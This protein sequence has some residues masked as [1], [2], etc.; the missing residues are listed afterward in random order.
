MKKYSLWVKSLCFIL[1]VVLFL[2]M[3]V[4][5]LGF[6]AAESVNMYG[7]EDYKEWR[8][9]RHQNMA[10]TLAAQVMTEYAAQQS[11]SPQWLLEQTG[12]V[13]AINNG[14]NWYELAEEDW[15]YT[16]LDPNGKIVA[17]TKKEL[18]D[19]MTFYFEN[20]ASNY[21]VIV[22]P[23]EPPIPETTV[24]DATEVPAYP[25]PIQPEE[26]VDTTPTQPVTAPTEASE[27]IYNADEYYDIYYDHTSDQE[28]WVQYDL[29]QGYQV[30][31]AVRADHSCYYASNG[32]PME[33][34]EWLFSVRYLLIAVAAGSLLLFAAVLVFLMII[35]GRSPKT[36]E[37]IPKALNCLP[38]DLY[39]A[40]A[41][42]GT[43]LG[44][45]FIYE[46]MDIVFSFDVYH[47]IALVLACSCSVVIAT[48][49]IGFF[50]ALAAQCKLPGGF[51]W[52]HT[53]CG[54]LLRWVFGWCAK[55]FR[56]AWKAA[57]KLLSMLPVVWEW[58]AV[59]GVLGILLLLICAGSTSRW[60]T[61]FPMFLWCLLFAAVVIYCGWCYG[62]IRKGIQRMNEGN[63]NEKID[64]KW[65][66]GS[67]RSIA[68]ELN[69]LA[70]VAA[71]AAEKQL[72]SERMKTELITNV[73]HDIKTP[74]TSVINYIDLLQK[75]HTEEDGEQYLEVLSRQSLRLKKLVEDLMDMSKA[76]T[77][78]MA[79]KI[80]KM[81]AVE[82]VNQ[83]LGEFSDKLDA[84]NLIPVF[85]TP[86][87]Q[88]HMLADG[89][90]TW[91][92]LSNIL[93]N[94]VKYA[95]PGTRVYVDLL[96]LDKTVVLSIKNISR[97]ELNISAEE[98]TERFV[99]G[100][101]SRNTEGSGL[102]L[103]IA[104]SLM[105]LQ[106]GNMDITVDGDL[107]KVTLI[108]PAE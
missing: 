63:L 103:N 28:V 57:G 77:G 14:M 97:E 66:Y 72:R 93:S 44:A 34:L 99:R 88:L 89:K 2:C 12:Y 78:N 31:I 98:L 94:V 1:S 86:D 60:Y 39:L 22:V 91:R 36:G 100:D 75:P 84:A 69:K 105:R 30:R 16:I 79:V 17:S 5:T 87:S 56:F 45:W 101:T 6:L 3:V 18:E 70:D 95:L 42:G 52:K 40:I 27:R 85:R 38:L 26:T 29:L 92:V 76:S 13:G 33:L 96:R 108:F 59:G 58:I 41:V 25:T 102:G 107:F 54:R 10:E 8:Y 68:E 4:G 7:Y 64:T 74:L 48:I 24:P 62:N 104:Q 71:I 19:P 11:G 106:R 50:M 51:W 49:D 82:A 80:E 9:S 65:M 20:M 90:L 15:Y 55:G 46:M 73:S 47:I 61:V 23:A 21:P 83:A 43:I 32:I 37:V 67:F 81:D 35:A 53:F